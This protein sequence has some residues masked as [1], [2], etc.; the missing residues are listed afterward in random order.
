LSSAN[1]FCSRCGT[2]I[3]PGAGFCPNCGLGV[4]V[5][6]PGQAAAAPAT[7]FGYSGSRRE[8]HE[9]NEKQEKH[10]KHEKNEKGRGSELTGAI[11]GGL[12]LIWLGVTFF[13]QE[14]NYISSGNWWAYFLMGIGAIL[15][16]QGVL[17]YLTSRRPFIGSFIGGAIILIIGLAFVQGFNADLWPLFLV[18]IGVAILL[19]AVVGRQRRPA[20]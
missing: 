7:S 2:Q 15:I 14:N 1:R 19:S 13:L 12:I 11:T 8:K 17:N 10:E 4:S 9:K 5:G 16:L 6:S 20:P 3:P 18:A